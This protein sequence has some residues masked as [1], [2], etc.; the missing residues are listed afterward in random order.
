METCS[1]NRDV[2]QLMA[3]ADT[4]DLETHSRFPRW[5]RSFPEVGRRYMLPMWEYALVNWYI[6]IVTADLSISR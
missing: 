6:G 4:E 3:V 1:D 2:G 5:I